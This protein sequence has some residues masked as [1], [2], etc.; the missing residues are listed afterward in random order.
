MIVTWIMETNMDEKK[1]VP[2]FPAAPGPPPKETPAL[3]PRPRWQDMIE[4]ERRYDP[5]RWLRH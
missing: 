2:N 3:P 4:P 5:L 1:P